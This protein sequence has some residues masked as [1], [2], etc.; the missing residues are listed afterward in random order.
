MILKNHFTGNN[1]KFTIYGFAFLLLLFAQGC[2]KQI[3][4]T[5]TLPEEEKKDPLNEMLIPTKIETGKLVT[6][7]KYQEGKSL[8]SEIIYPGGEVCKIIYTTTDLPRRLERYKNKKQVQYFSYALDTESRISKIQRWDDN[9]NNLVLAHQ[10][11]VGYDKQTVVSVKKYDASSNLAEEET[12][13]YAMSGNPETITWIKNKDTEAQ[14]WAYDDKNGT[15]TQLPYARLFFLEEI[16]RDLSMGKGNPVSVSSLK[17][18]SENR[19]FHYTY[20][21]SGY[22]SEITIKKG[23]STE[24]IKISYK[25]IKPG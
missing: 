13:A 6:E 8:L 3:P 15:F 14:R 16:Y 10:Y 1:L 7:L 25:V 23:N 5:G 19:T 22:P 17:I 12:L 20:N 21:N 9:N 4:L 24:S 2:K 11:T 18:P